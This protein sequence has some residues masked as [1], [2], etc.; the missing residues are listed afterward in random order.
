VNK[1]MK[2]EILKVEKCHLPKY[3]SKGCSRL[4]STY[5]MM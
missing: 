3:G 5:N 1:F 2:R 4:I